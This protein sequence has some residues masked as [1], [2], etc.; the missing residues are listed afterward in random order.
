M[1]KLETAKMYA[2]AATMLQKAQQA[3]KD[4]Q[5]VLEKENTEEAFE[6]LRYAR[7]RYHSAILTKIKWH[8]RIMGGAV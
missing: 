6:A 8:A 4:A 3:Y 1:T 5:H 7:D 2:A